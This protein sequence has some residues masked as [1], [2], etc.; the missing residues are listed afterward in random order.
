MKICN[1]SYYI[2][3]TSFLRTAPA[4]KFARFSESGFSYNSPHL[5]FAVRRVNT[6]K[7]ELLVICGGDVKLKTFASQKEAVDGARKLVELDEQ[8]YKAKSL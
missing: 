1:T 4:K 3:M 5:A 7:Y 8:F 2:E 6:N